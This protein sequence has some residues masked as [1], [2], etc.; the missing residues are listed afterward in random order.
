MLSRAGI[1]VCIGLLTGCAQ[2][3]HA[4]L[5]EIDNRSGAMSKAKKIDIKVSET[6]VNIKELADVARAVGGKRAEKG[7]S[8]VEDIVAAFQQGPVT[9]ER[10]FNDKYAENMIAMLKV[11]CP[12]G[13]LT[14]LMSVRESRKYPVISGEIVKVTGYCVTQ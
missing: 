8:Q 3:H 13:K 9:G 1:V 5:G 2:L 6:G 12:S 11:E 7:T 14:G 4:Q 10:V